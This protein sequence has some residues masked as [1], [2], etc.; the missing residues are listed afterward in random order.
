MMQISAK[1]MELFEKKLNYKEKVK[2]KIVPYLEKA[3]KC[4]LGVTFLPADDPL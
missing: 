2:L 1:M 4:R 3:S